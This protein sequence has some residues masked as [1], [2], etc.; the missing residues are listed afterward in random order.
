MQYGEDD[1]LVRFVWQGPQAFWVF[2]DTF[3]AFGV[4]GMMICYEYRD[5]DM[6]GEYMASLVFVIHQSR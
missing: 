4:I 2:V 6:D 1:W 5:R 3:S